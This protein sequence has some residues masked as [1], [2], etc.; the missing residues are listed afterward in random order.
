M[1][2]QDPSQIWQSRLIKHGLYELRRHA[3]MRPLKPRAKRFIFLRHGETEGNAKRV[4]Q[5]ADIPLNATGEAQARRAAEYLR[6]H[7]VERI[8]ASDMRRAWQTAEA[9]AQTVGASVIPEPRLRERWFG[10]LVGTSSI[11]L[12]WRIDPPNGETLQQ[13]VERT[14]TG[15]MH[16]LDTDASTLLVAHGGSLYVLVYSLGADLLEDHISNAT[17]LLFEFED[18]ASC[19]RISNIAPKSVTNEYLKTAD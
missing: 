12:D 16:A 2:T 7:P 17:P 13:F 15:F 18:S 11:D 1:A 14:Q 5:P 10:D 4:Y 6:E 8:L 9:A 19:W 3:S